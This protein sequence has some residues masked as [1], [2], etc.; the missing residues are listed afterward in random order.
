MGFAEKKLELYKIVTEAD[1]ETTAKLIDFAQKLNQ[2]KY[3]FSEAELNEFKERRED[4]LKNPDS[5]IPWE[6]ALGKI[7]NKITK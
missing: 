1:E 4:F 7:R 6:E 5:A 2:S 3:S